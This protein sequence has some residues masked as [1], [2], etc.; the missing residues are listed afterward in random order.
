MNIK[1]ALS[2]Y[3]FRN[4]G[5][6][7][8][9]AESLGYKVSY[10]KGMFN[11]VRRD[12]NIHMSIK[13]IREH[14]SEPDLAME[15]ISKER[16]CKFFDRNQ[17]LSPEYAEILAK[18][19]VNIINWGDLKE[20]AK[21]RFTVI[22]LTHKICY[23][24]K[25]LYEY[26]N[27]NNYLLDGKGTILEKGIMSE[28]T[29]I[30]GKP[31]KARLTE[32]GISIFYRKEALTIPDRIFN[33]KLSS[34]QKQ[35]LLDGNI[36]VLSTNKGDVMLQIDRDLN[37][38]VVRSKKELA[39]PQEIGGYEL[40]SADKY[41]LANGYSLENKV[42][43]TE[44]GYM[45]ANISMNADKKG[46]AFSNI[47]MIPEAK[48]KELLAPQKPARDMDAELQEALSKNDFEKMAQLK[49][50]GYKPSEEVIQGLGHD[51]NLSQAQ[52]ITIEKLFGI[53]PEIQ[54]TEEVVST[55]KEAHQEEMELNAEAEIKKE[56]TSAKDQEF[57]SAVKDEDFIK[58]SMM[59]D[60]GY[61]PSHEI[62]QTLSETTTE[63]NVIAVQ[64]IYGLKPTSTKTLGDIKLANNQNNEKNIK[65]P[66]TNLIRQAFNDL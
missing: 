30:K 21:D 2:E 36:I 15:D 4:A 58:I 49:E 40:T 18:E 57:I 48:A 42:L 66:L 63:N 54:H 52:A 60:E 6:F 34:K 35:D 26:A 47:Q 45:I 13:E 64:K 51:N 50:E 43:H 38:V 41:L 32:N 44:E 7:S 65:Q 46:Y 39:I 25:E 37:A 61:Q 23:T 10:K 24:G 28:M 16:I 29:Q 62:M 59:K 33:K 1:E 12:E 17:I 14:T 11:F 53:K 8:G 27:E 3:K 20:D 31:A 9:I 19:G 56:I 22:D 55:G 5:Q